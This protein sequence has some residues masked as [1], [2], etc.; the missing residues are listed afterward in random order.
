[1]FKV[2]PVN[3]TSRHGL[4]SLPRSYV[5]AAA[6]IKFPVIRVAVFAISAI[7]PPD[8]PV[9]EA[10]ITPVLLIATPVP[11]VKAEIARVFVKYTL[12][13]VVLPDST[14]S[15]ADSTICPVFPAT[16]TTFAYTAPVE[17]L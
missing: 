4:V 16:L 3:H 2:L 9:N 7:T 10:E 11:A 14:M 1:M 15:L 12:P 5:P 8:T 13:E 17:A 6:G